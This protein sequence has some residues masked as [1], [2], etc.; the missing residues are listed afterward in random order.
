MYTARSEPGRV[1]LGKGKKE[2]NW[3][4]QA[5]V[6]RGTSRGMGVPIEWLVKNMSQIS[7]P[8]PG[9]AHFQGSRPRG[10][11]TGTTYPAA[12]APVRILEALAQSRYHRCPGDPLSPVDSALARL[13]C[14]PGLELDLESQV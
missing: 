9:T 2:G 4:A 7:S 10:Q 14:G 3:S 8:A 11:H 1:D 5:W 13:A 6:I 12:F